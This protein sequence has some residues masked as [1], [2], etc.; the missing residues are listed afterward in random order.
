MK[1]FFEEKHVQHRA[2]LS[3][4]EEVAE[5]GDQAEV[6]SSYWYDEEPPL[7]EVVKTAK[8]RGFDVITIESV[9]TVQKGYE[10][11]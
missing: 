1:P 9:T 3:R 5:K 2:L 8:E 4:A 7:K 11:E 10:V 6:V